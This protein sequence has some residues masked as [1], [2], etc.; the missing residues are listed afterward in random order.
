M[1]WTVDDVERFRKGLTET[2]KMQWVAVANEALVR[3]LREGEDDCDAVAIRQANAAIGAAE[4]SSTLGDRILGAVFDEGAPLKAT[5][6]GFLRAAQAVTRHPDAPQKVKDQI[7]S[8]REEL[9]SNTWSAIASEAANPSTTQDGGAEGQDRAPEPIGEA[10]SWGP[11]HEV[12][13]IV[14]TFTEDGALVTAGG[15]A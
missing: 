6:Q 13:T 9:S 1:P 12:G 5:V 15:G 4:E 7:N 11:L 2:E 10:P 14:A 8:L 3:C